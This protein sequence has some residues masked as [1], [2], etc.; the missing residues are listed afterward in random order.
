MD[1]IDQSKITV[2]PWMTSSVQPDYLTLD[3]IRELS[4]QPKKV[5]TT[6]EITKIFED[7]NN[8]KETALNINIGSNLPSHQTSPPETALD[9]INK[10][11][12]EE[13]EKDWFDV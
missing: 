7:M 3:Q 5:Y 4:T 1:N 8:L 2:S 6:E 12:P 10:I 9:D 13:Q 11:L